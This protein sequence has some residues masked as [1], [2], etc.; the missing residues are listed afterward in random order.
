MNNLVHDVP[1][2]MTRSERTS[3]AGIHVRLCF[4]NRTSTQSLLRVVRGVLHKR[5][6]HTVTSSSVVRLLH[7]LRLVKAARSPFRRASCS[8]GET[9]ERNV[10]KAHSCCQTKSSFGFAHFHWYFLRTMLGANQSE[11]TLIRRCRASARRVFLR[12]FRDHNMEGE[13]CIGVSASRK[14]R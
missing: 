10:A 8:L 13:C 11:L 5:I 14:N 3:R 7:R 12:K 1:P 2:T 4:R 6:G 9:F